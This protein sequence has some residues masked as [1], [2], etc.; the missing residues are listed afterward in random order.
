MSLPF[1]FDCETTAQAIV[2][3]R[4][5]VLCCWYHFCHAHWT[6]TRFRWESY[7]Q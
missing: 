5:C 7:F 1:L 4:V 6:H 2:R 3:A